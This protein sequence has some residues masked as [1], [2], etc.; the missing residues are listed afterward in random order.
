MCMSILSS[1]LSFSLAFVCVSFF[2]QR[3]A[4]SFSFSSLAQAKGER[5][6]ARGAPKPN[7]PVSSRMLQDYF[8]FRR[9]EESRMGNRSE[10]ASE[11]DRVDTGL[12]LR[13]CY[14]RD[15]L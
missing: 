2:L 7:S 11:R 12:I 8:L 1:A 9:G 6:S 10:R 15:I 13:V 14:A 5:A 3:V 4:Q